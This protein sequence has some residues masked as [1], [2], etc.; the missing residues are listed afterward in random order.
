MKT[1]ERLM[2][3]YLRDLEPYDSPGAEEDKDG[4]IWVNA[5]EYPTATVY[6]ERFDTLNR[7]P[8]IQPK[9]FC[10][11]YARYAGLEPEEVLVTRGADEGIELLIRTFCDP[12]TDTV[13]YPAPTYSMYRI[14][15]RTCGVRAEAVPSQDGWHVDIEALCERLKDGKE[16]KGP[17]VKLVFFCQPNNPTGEL[18]SE[19]TIRRLVECA[20]EDTLVAIDEAYIEFTPEST[21]VSLMKDY[22]NV[23]IIRTLSKAFALAGL[24]CG[25]L[26]ARREII[27]ALRKV[28]APY[29]VPAPV[30]QIAAQALSD[31]GL[32]LMRGR[33]ETINQNRAY[34]V[35]RLQALGLSV[36]PSVTNFVLIALDEAPSVYRRLWQAGVAAR[37]PGDG[38]TLRISIGTRAECEAIADQLQRIRGESL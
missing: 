1:V 14:S 2:P 29:P 19:P 16:G 23:V 5:N 18:F 21:M 37:D 20:G 33:V 36:Y 31:E 38:K 30:G 25:L 10:R 6:E 22:A 9:L 3:A 17:A 26:L 32:A 28:I 35:R 4:K 34:F 8:E 7:Y 27:A 24:R 12:Q 11:R 15:S 13:L